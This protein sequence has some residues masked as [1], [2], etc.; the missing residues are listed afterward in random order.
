VNRLRIL[1]AGLGIFLAVGF[2]V[3][4]L[5]SVREPHNNASSNATVIITSD[6]G[7]TLLD[8][9]QFDPALGLTG[10]EMLRNM[11]SVE[12]RYGGM[13]VY[14]MYGLRSDLSKRLD[15]LYYVNGVYMDRGLASYKPRAGEVVQ[16]DYH[17]WGSYS[18]SPGFLSGYPAKL[19][20]GLQG[21]KDNTTIV[22]GGEASEN[23][24]ELA[25]VLRR[26]TG[27]EPRIAEPSSASQDDLDANLIILATPSAASFYQEVQG[28][29]RNAY[30]FS[31]FEGGK[32]WLNGLARGERTELEQGCTVMCMDFP[33]TDKWAVMVFG[34]DPSW[35]AR[36]LKEL[37][38]RT[39]VGYC[40]AFAVTPSGVVKL[41]VE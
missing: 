37:S 24:R 7:K 30:W 35:M 25:K 14:S 18:A 28:W 19:I 3:P 16:V 36:G 39:L 32:L 31:S 40:A 9:R 21:Q 38:E 8:E 33:G 15:W 11:T 26:L 4:Y 41:P 27:R 6:Y 10:M 12:T 17:Y 29:R 22:A 2:A 34:T 5:F 20:F 1:L 13:Y 23:A